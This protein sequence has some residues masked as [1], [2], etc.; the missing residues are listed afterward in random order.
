M[1]ADPGMRA[2][3]RWLAFLRVVV[4]AWFAKGAVTK[5][6]LTLGWG[7]LPLP[8]ASD[9]WTSAMPKLLARY[10]ADDPFQSYRAFLLDTVIP[11]ARLFATLTAFG[12]IFVGVSL[13]LGLLTPAGAAVGL[14]LSILYGMTVQH[15][16]PGQQGFHVMLIAMMLAF[17]FARAGRAWGLDARLR[18][19]RPDSFVAR[20][21]T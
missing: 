13:L 9:R 16:S 18:A 12:E 7:W 20:W 1:D 3:A 15:M 2:P 10:A 6:A 21:L 4:G 14:V 17:H 19:R 11:N 8:I 5:V